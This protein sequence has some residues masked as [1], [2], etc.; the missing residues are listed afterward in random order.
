MN[1]EDTK[2]SFETIL[3]E[4]RLT[5][6]RARFEPGY[7]D[8][9][10]LYSRTS[11]LDRLKISTPMALDR[12]LLR[13]SFTYLKRVTQEIE[14]DGACILALTFHAFHEPPL[15]PAI[16][17]CNGREIAAEFLDSTTF[18][19]PAGQLG[20]YLEQLLEELGLADEAV[21]EEVD[22]PAGGAMWF[23]GR[24]KRT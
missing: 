16:Y 8:E 23:V 2:L 9:V 21:V 14:T 19:T 7:W 24:V 4:E 1:D 12:L 13:L 10:P 5:S 11:Q 20:I 17:V 15:L 6:P 22:D 18:R 3:Q